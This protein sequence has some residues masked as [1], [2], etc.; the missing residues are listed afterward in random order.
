MAQDLQRRFRNDFGRMNEVSDA[1]VK[2]TAPFKE[3]WNDAYLHELASRLHFQRYAYNRNELKKILARF[4]FLYFQ[5]I[6]QAN[7]SVVSTLNDVIALTETDL[8]RVWEPPPAAS[9]A[10]YKANMSQTDSL[11]GLHIGVLPAMV[12]PNDEWTV[13]QRQQ[14]QQLLATYDQ[15]SMEGFLREVS[16]IIT[17]IDPAGRSTP[18]K[19]SLI[20]LTSFLALTLYRFA[21]KPHPAMT[22]TFKKNQYR[23][24]L[25]SLAGWVAEA[26]FSPPCDLCLSICS[27]ALVKGLINTSKLFTKIVDEFVASDHPDYPNTSVP[28]VLAAAVLTHTARN[29]LGI[30]QML[31][32]VTII[33][34]TNWKEV[35]KSTYF[36]LT[37]A[38]WSTIMEM[39]V[40]QRNRDNPQ[41]S[42]HWARIIDHGFFRGLAPKENRF[43]ATILAAVI[44]QVQGEEVWEAEWAK[45][46]PIPQ[47]ARMIGL[48]GNGPR[49]DTSFSTSLC[50]VIELEKLKRMI[51]GFG[52]Q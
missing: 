36:T 41:K 32:N 8:G 16:R 47:S 45:Q 5:G 35:A 1:F 13:V 18:A 10:F 11:E 24:N 40:S 2:P 38:S 52:G 15:R 23:N 14:Y 51:P 20:R 17:A 9:E 50:T 39:F 27:G 31:E 22:N 3:G 19:T 48:Q 26:P 30:L 12:F 44:A 33:L 29:G 25:T 21:T 43:L 42:Y 49:C 34:D 7:D 46:A 4:Y 6:N 28:G 37:A